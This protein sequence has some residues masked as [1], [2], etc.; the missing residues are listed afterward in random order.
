MNEGVDDD[1]GP[2]AEGVMSR[3]VASVSFPSQALRSV[4]CQ[5]CGRT[6]LR[7]PAASGLYCLLAVLVADPRGSGHLSGVAA[8][9]VSSLGNLSAAARCGSICGPS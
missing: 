9:T 3:L 7:T 4:V 2:A 1:R 8:V 6:A 5:T